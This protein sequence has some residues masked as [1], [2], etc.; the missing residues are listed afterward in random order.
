MNWEFFMNNL[1]GFGRSDV[2]FLANVDYQI[3]DLPTKVFL[4]IYNGEIDGVKERPFIAQIGHI[5][6]LEEYS[7]DVLGKHYYMF[8]L[9]GELTGEVN[10]NITITGGADIN[11]ADVPR[12][13]M[14]GRDLGTIHRALAPSLEKC[15][16]SIEQARRK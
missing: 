14:A 11:A 9:K 4:G 16:V 10:G 12:L 3:N 6:H 15:I 8:G 5:W 7:Q 2:G 13:V 1:P